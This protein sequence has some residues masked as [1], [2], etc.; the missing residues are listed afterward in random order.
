MSAVSTSHGQFDETSQKE[1]K[2]VGIGAEKVNPH[3]GIRGDPPPLVYL[4]QHANTQAKELRQNQGRP[5]AE[6]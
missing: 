2:Q 4:K 5:Q 3:F 1:K 6:K